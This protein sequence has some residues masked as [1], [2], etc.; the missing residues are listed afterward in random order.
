MYKVRREIKDSQFVKEA[1]YPHSIEG[2]G[3]VEEHSACQPSLAE[4]PSYSFNDSGQLQELA[5]PGS[6]PKLLIPQQ[7]ILA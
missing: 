7:P 3:H 4:V 5:K 6:K 1:F 2:F